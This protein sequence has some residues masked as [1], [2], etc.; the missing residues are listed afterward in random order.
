MCKNKDKNISFVIIGLVNVCFVH[1][2]VF[3]LFKEIQYIVFMIFN[4]VLKTACLISI[5][6]ND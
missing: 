5:T 2:K 4:Q 3:K 1:F 6:T